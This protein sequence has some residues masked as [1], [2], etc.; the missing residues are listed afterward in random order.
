MLAA[1]SE[2][3]IR[4][5][6]L[7]YYPGAQGIYLFGTYGTE[8]ERP[9]SDIDIGRLLPIEQARREKNLAWSACRLA[10]EDALT[11]EVDLLNVREVSTVLQKEIIYQGNLI[12]AADQYAVDEFEM[13][14]LSYYQKLNEERTGIIEEAVNSRRFYQV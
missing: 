12:Y 6:V 14:V 7:R 1:Q 11:K 13:L 3:T 8:D 2:S 5:V 9:D 10:L 4:E